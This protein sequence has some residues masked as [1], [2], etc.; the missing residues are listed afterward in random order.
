MLT[1][2]VLSVMLANIM[3]VAAA[4]PVIAAQYSFASG[5]TASQS[6]SQEGGQALPLSRPARRRRQ[7]R[8][9][10]HTLASHSSRRQ[11]KQTRV[12][13]SS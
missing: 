4:L 2:T 11:T 13:G 12:L 3:S 7:D 5:G 8:T 10:P 6:S 9:E 1:E